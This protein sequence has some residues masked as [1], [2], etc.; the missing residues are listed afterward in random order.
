MAVVN[1]T[2]APF[3]H[4]KHKHLG[5]EA[6]G[7]HFR[8]RKVATGAGQSRGA[9]LENTRIRPGPR[10]AFKGPC[11]ALTVGQGPVFQSVA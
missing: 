9:T 6:T 8:S 7:G 1:A 3:G 11:N 5:T 10:P 4:R 2:I